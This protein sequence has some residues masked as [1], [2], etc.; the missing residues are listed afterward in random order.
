MPSPDDIIHYWFGELLNG[1]TAENRYPLWFEGRIEDDAEMAERFGVAI[2]AALA[3]ELE[4]WLQSP[5]GALAYILLLDQMTRATRRNTAEAYA[6]D[7]RALAACHRGLDSNQDQAL[8]IVY[9]TFFYLPLEH[10]ESL[11]DQERCVSL[12]NTLRELALNAATADIEEVDRMAE[13]LAK[14]G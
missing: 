3:G 5:T 2:D 14:R 12:F 9:R 1:W 6:G 10:S 13:L 8:P 4:D 7:V 11:A